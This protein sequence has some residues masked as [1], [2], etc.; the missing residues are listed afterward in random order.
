[1]KATLN[2]V[3]FF[4][5]RVWATLRGEDCVNPIQ[6]RNIDLEISYRKKRTGLKPVPKKLYRVRL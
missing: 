4:Y 5:D 3:A 6:P 1:M 2:R